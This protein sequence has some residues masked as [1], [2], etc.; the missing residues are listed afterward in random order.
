MEI[1]IKVGQK[2]VWLR[3]TEKAYEIC[4]MKD[5][6]PEK[7]ATPVPTLVPFL[8]YLSLQGAITRLLDMKVRASDA[9]TM[10]DLAEVIKRT[11]KE[12]AITFDMEA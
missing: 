1:E 5:I 10:N 2:S 7:G 3:G 11:K 6:A 9:T 8:W 12:L 4:E